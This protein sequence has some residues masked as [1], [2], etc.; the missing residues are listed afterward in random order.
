MNHLAELHEL[1]RKAE[2]LAFNSYLRTGQ[3]PED[4]TQLIF[5]S[6]QLMLNIRANPDW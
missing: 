6:K 3:V 5:E 2:R 1:Q 4:L